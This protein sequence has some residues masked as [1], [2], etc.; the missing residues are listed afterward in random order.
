MQPGEPRWDQ[1]L[2]FRDRLRSAPALIDEYARLETTAAR[3]HPHDREAYTT[4]KYAFVHRVLH[5]SS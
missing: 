2:T 4:A 1:Q 5:D 3:Q